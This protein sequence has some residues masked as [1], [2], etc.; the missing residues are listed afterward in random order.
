MSRSKID[1]RRGGLAR[2]LVALALFSAGGAGCVAQPKVYYDYLE[3]VAGPGD[4][5]TEVVGEPQQV[6]QA[7]LVA[8]L[9]GTPFQVTAVD[10]EGTFVVAQYSGPPEPYVDCGTLLEVPRS[11]PRMVKRRA[12]A[13]ASSEMTTNTGLWRRDMRLDGRL[14]ARLAPGDAGTAVRTDATYVLS[15][16]MRKPDTNGVVARETIA[17]PTGE[18]AAFARG[19]TCQPTGAFEQTVLAAL[20]RSADLQVEIEPAAGVAPEESDEVVAGL[21]GDP[22]LPAILN[23]R[24]PV[25]VEPLPQPAPPVPERDPALQALMMA[26]VPEG[27]CGAVDAFRLG[28]DR[29]AVE[30]VASDL[31]AMD[32]MIN[33]IEFRYA[34]L[35]VDN[36]I[37]V[38]PP[39]ACEAYR[40]AA[41]QAGGAGAG[42]RLEILDLRDGRLEQGD[43]V[44]L[45]LGVPEGQSHVHLSYFRSSGQV[46]HVEFEMPL[47]IA[48]DEAWLVDT[49]QVVDAPYGREFI[50]AIATEQPLFEEPRP[51]LEP[52]STFLPELEAALGVEPADITTACAILTTT[53]DR[54]GPTD[55]APPSGGPCTSPV[56]G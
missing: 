30:G 27:S 24:V 5:T 45:A 44:R 14:V 39:G 52:A 22:P 38:L 10:P 26:A 31:F 41:N 47:E 36:R 1:P 55:P 2:V 29:L 7:K 50:L 16:L 8:G 21:R 11:G 15:K 56:R 28:S 51:A 48:P 6:I 53:G 37:E 43:I 35:A 9:E 25:L 17:F 40:L 42:A 3:P 54:S 33:A 49:H 12:A 23:V 13:T 32:S 20:E 46:A 4:P 34:D 19:T 18:R